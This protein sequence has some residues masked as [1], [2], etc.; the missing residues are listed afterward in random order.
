MRKL[1]RIALMG[2]LL[3][4]AGSS[5]KA[6]DVSIGVRIGPPPVARVERG[7]P[8]RPGPDFVWV[9]G[10]WYPSHNRYV[11]HRGYWTRAPFAGARW[12]APRHEGGRF[13]A[14]YWDGDRGRFNHDHR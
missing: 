8:P 1:T 6:A 3:L 12:V 14:G 7:Q 11:W 9:D 10:Y 13:F 5:V 4:G 2:L